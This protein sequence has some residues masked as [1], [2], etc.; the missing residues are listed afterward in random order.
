MKEEVLS[1]VDSLVLMDTLRILPSNDRRV[2]VCFHGY[3]MCLVYSVL[4]LCLLAYIYYIY[5]KLRN[6]A[7]QF[8]ISYSLVYY[9]SFFFIIT[10][11][12]ERKITVLGDYLHN[13]H[14]TFYLLSYE[15]VHEKKNTLLMN[16]LTKK[17]LDLVFLPSGDTAMCV[18]VCVCACVS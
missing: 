16:F 17:V 8:E 2:C 13:N 1:A 12:K 11:Y 15:L 3:C 14:V 4:L 5:I 7:M 9:S 6:Q 18:C 10:M